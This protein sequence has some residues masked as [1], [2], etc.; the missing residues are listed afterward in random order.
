[1]RRLKLVTQDGFTLIEI[2]VGMAIVL[3]LTLAIIPAY[4]GH[5][6]KSQR[7]DAKISLL[8]WA[9]A[10]ERYYT[11]NNAYYVGGTSGYIYPI[12]SEDGYYNLSYGV[13]TT[14]AYT[15]RASPLNVTQDEDCQTLTLDHLGVKAVIA[16]PIAGVPLPRLNAKAC[17]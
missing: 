12:T 5:I 4:K 2:V 10:M 9:Q 8:K 17:W 15:L 11:E 7:S 16:D 13:Q 1:M 14:T 3:I 6:A